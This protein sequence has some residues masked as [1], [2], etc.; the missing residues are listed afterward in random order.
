ME[1]NSSNEP[2]IPSI[3][4]N[5]EELPLTEMSPRIFIAA[6]SLPGRVELRV[7]VNPGTSPCRATVGLVIPLLAKASSPLIWLIAD[8]RDAFFCE[9]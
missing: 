4:I 5:G 7:M 6:P 3:I 1:F 2:V 9:P 8:V